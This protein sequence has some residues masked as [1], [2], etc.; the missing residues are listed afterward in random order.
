MLHRSEVKVIFTESRLVFVHEA[1]DISLICFKTLFLDDQG[2][3][4]K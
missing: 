2:I 1:T 3:K 4:L